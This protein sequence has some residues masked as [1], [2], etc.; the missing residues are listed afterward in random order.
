[1][2]R[3]FLLVPLAL[4]VVLGV[5]CNR[6]SETSGWMSTAET[7][8][9]I[10]PLE[11]RATSGEQ[12][13]RRWA[14]GLESRWTDGRAEHRVTTSPAPAGAYAWFWCINL[15]K[16]KL[17]G[18]LEELDAKGFRLVGSLSRVTWPDGSDRFSGVWHKEGTAAGEGTP[19][20]P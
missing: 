11:A 16:E 19:A 12:T 6:A 17:S 18:R 15:P 9:F 13:E 4:A 10:K 5:G 14:S 1:M 20:T 7:V 2:A 8:E 3:P